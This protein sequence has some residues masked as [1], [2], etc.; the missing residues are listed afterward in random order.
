MGWEKRQRG[1]SYYYRSVRIDGR[2]RKIYA[3][4]GTIGEMNALRDT[5]SHMARASEIEAWHHQKSG[6]ILV[7]EKLKHLEIIYRLLVQ[8]TL[9]TLG[10]YLHHRQWRRRSLRWQPVKAESPRQKRA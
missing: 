3:G 7:D 4:T 10:L 6:L 8:G 2:T 1:G 5:K 9:L